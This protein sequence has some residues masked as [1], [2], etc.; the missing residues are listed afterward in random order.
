M[1]G[2][3][4]IPVH[5]VHPSQLSAYSSLAGALTPATPISQFS[6][7]TR[8][9][10]PQTACKGARQG[11]ALRDFSSRSGLPQLISGA[12]EHV[13]AGIKI[14]KI[15]L[16]IMWLG[17]EHV[18]GSFTFPIS[19][20]ITKGQLGSLIAKQ[21]RKFCDKAASSVTGAPH[22]GIGPGAI[23][24]DQLYLIGLHS[25]GDGVCQADI[26]VDPDPATS[27]NVLF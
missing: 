23:T 8:E 13:L 18:D 22:W 14:H 2:Y 11:V 4:D 10:V 17:Y 5:A 16:R 7:S 9:R 21:F 24:F 1:A 25:F 26:A 27:R 15:D 20:T 19:T 3:S 6:S 12:N